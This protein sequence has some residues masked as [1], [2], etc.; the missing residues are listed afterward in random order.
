MKKKAYAAL[1]LSAAMVVQTMPVYAQEVSSDVSGTTYTSSTDEENAVLVDGNS[2]TLTN[3][4]VN[5]TGEASGDEADFYGVNAAV[6]ATNGAT[7]TI[8]D[9][10]VTTNGAHANGI[11]A[12]G[13][14]T[15]VNV[16]DTVIT[17]SSNCSGGIMT[18]G[19]ATMNASDLTITTSGGSSAAIRSDRGGGDVN[20]EGGTYK[21]SGSG[22][23][24][25]YSTADITVED[26]TLTATTSE[27]VV[28]EGGNS[29]TLVNCNTTGNNTKNSQ[30][31]EYKNVL[32]YQ[33]MSGDASNGTS[34][35][36]MTGGSMTANNGHM[37]FVT[38]TTCTIN[39]SDVDFTYADGD[40]LRAAADAWGNSGSNGGQVTLNVT[41]QDIDGDITVDE[42]SSLNFY[43]VDSDYEGAISGGGEVYV[44][45]DADSEW[46]LTGN[47]EIAALTCDE[48]AIDLNGYTL[49]VNGETY[50]EGTASEGEEVEM[51]TSGSSQGMGEGFGAPGM[52]EMDTEN[53]TFT[54]TVT[55]VTDS[56]ITIEMS[57]MPGGQK[58]GQKPEKKED[59]TEE[60]ESEE[61]TTETT[62]DSD[63]KGKQ[64]PG[65]KGQGGPGGEKP[66]GE[67]PSG[68]M[69]AGGPGG[70]GQGGPGGEMPG[71]EAPSG[72]M[73]SGEAP[74]GEK[75][76]GDMPSGEKP[77]DASETT[78]GT[79]EAPAEGEKPA[80]GMNERTMELTFETSED[81]TAELAV[82]DIV[83]V[84]VEN[85]VVVSISAGEEAGEEPAE[86]VKPESTETAPK[87]DAPAAEEKAEDTAKETKGIGG[88]IEAIKSFF[89]KLFG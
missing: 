85:G 66:S 2:V 47:T 21:T 22:S 67:A 25:I 53:G 8:T 64:G 5:K 69:P 36:T 72:E 33:S 1:L 60:T 24:A 41:D 31:S 58:D 11:F 19:G 23:P 50:T 59:T 61:E 27:A 76:S 14:G 63:Q 87:N 82:G 38:N 34:S 28:V 3:I 52:D 40:F 44:Q 73:P 13:E 49:T 46:V 65:G 89:S 57:G 20:V 56:S 37:F 12:Y 51:E 55:E 35:F 17:T 30:S 79:G 43:L 74:S 83:T 80:D 6:L 15:T 4:S 70:N 10:E 54:G 78:E 42:S 75:P 39:L 88:V 86:E 9:S 62:E 29:V 45:L 77:E 84:T 68:D 32:I 18:T 16:S 48:D 7:L 26:A 81:Y 71:G